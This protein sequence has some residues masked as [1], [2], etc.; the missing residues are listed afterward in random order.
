MAGADEV[1]S[2]VD[3]SN[4]TSSKGGPDNGEICYPEVS[5]WG[6]TGTFILRAEKDLPP[7]MQTAYD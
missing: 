3:L 6:E 2:I 1:V 5:L 4:P 7:T